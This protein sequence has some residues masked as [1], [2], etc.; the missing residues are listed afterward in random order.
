MG[1]KKNYFS[2]IKNIGYLINRYFIKSVKYCFA[3]L[4]VVPISFFTPKKNILFIG[5]DNGRFIDNTKYLLLYALDRDEYLGKKYFLTEDKNTFNNLI[6]EDIP[7]IFYPS[8]ESFFIMLTTKVVV[9]D[10]ERWIGRI[11]YHYLFNALKI[12]LWHAVPTKQIGL[13]KKNSLIKEGE[14][15]LI[16]RI[17]DKIKG[18]YCKYDVFNSTSKNLISTTFSE[19]FDADRFISFGY[20]RNDVLFS[21]GNEKYMISTDQCSIGKIISNKYNNLRLVLYAPTFRKHKRETYPPLNTLKLSDFCKENNIF[22]L[23][24]HHYR[25]DSIAKFG[26]QDLSSIIYYDNECDIYPIL[27]NI[28]LIIT[29]YSS[30]Y[31]DTLLINKKVIFFP[32][33]IEEYYIDSNDRLDYLEK[34]PGPKCFHQYEL[35]EEIINMLNTSTDNYSQKRIF[36]KNKS[37]DETSSGASERLWSYICNL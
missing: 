36:M 11:K 14:Y 4:V 8:F 12:Q 7:A 33:D 26:E 23:I 9:V 6:S 15:P 31:I 13:I 34:T 18:A 22:F 35:H 32:Y 20:P 30:I 3:W 19:A 17:L 25:P 5:R 24:K 16:K 1:D 10:S 28:D 27:S 21:N 29:D 37:F 2:S